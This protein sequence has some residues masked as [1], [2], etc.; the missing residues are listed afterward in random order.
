MISTLTSLKAESH[1]DIDVSVNS[2][3]MHSF[4]PLITR[5]TRFSTYNSSLIDNIFT[6][7]SQD[8]LISGIL[9]SDISDHLSIYHIMQK[10]SNH[11]KTKKK[12]KI[13]GP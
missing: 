12:S 8:M 5:P 10:I 6:N 2:V 3:F 9:I 4:I 13:I 1:S 7:Q 11:A